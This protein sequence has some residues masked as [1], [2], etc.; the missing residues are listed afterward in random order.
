MM[1]RSGELLGV[2]RPGARDYWYPAWQ[3]EDTGK[4]LPIMRRLLS[5]A[6]ESG[7]RPERLNELVTMRSG[8]TGGGRLLDAIRDGRDEYVIASVRSAGKTAS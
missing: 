3:W 5:A 7:V 6:R 1:R 8:L 2:R 4:P